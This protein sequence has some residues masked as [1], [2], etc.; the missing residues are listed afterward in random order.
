M[1]NRS[2]FGAGAV[3][4]S[5]AAALLV[6]LA[7][8]VSSQGDTLA[9]ITPPASLP[10]SLPADAVA[11]PAQQPRYAAYLCEGGGALTVENFQTS[12][13]VVGPNRESA[14]LPAS[15]SGQ[16]RRYA[17]APYVLELDGSRATFSR[18]G[19]KPLS[20]ARTEP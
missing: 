6:V 5:S 8:C 10:S 15:P 11:V 9:A 17:A 7:G 3:C 16:T 12:A 2:F 18:K 14:E 13:L 19:R 20:C 1:V 4:R